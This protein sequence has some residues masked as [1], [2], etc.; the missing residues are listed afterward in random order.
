[1]CAVVVIGARRVTGRLTVAV[2][3]RRC[4]QEKRA[5]L[6]EQG[7]ADGTVR[8]DD[9]KQYVHQLR[10]KSAVYKKKR[11]EVGELRA[12]FG[13]LSR[14]LEILKGKDAIIA[15]MVVSLQPVAPRP[16]RL[17]ASGPSPSR[18]VLSPPKASHSSPSRLTQ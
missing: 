9:F 2:A 3:A 1:M 17:G 10:G 12:E 15:N 5:Q 6:E 7:G 18:P 16:V 11:L 8:G 13:V 14:T 4:V